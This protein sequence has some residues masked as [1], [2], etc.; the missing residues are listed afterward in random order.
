MCAKVLPEPRQSAFAVGVALNLVVVLVEVVAG[1]LAGSMA[2]LADAG[3]NA[4]DVLAVALAWAAAV[5]ARG[6]PSG[7]H[8]Y[9]L[10]STTIFAAAFNAKFGRFAT[11]D[12][13][14]R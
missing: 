12:G 1:L 14:A 9:G 10:R 3:H 11:P 13:G 5:L 4:A 7:R 8:T 2:L 6:R